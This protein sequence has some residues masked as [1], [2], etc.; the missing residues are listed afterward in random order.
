MSSQISAGHRRGS[1]L[2][3]RVME[4][5]FAEEVSFRNCFG[6]LDDWV[7]TLHTQ[8][9]AVGKFKGGKGPREFSAGITEKSENRENEV[10]L[11]HFLLSRW[12]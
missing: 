7:K 6:K 5:G 8:S 1:L 11:T 2:P 12:Q 3:H 10:C 9:I 4:K